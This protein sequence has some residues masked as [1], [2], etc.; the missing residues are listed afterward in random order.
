M[1]Y[2]PTTIVDNFYEN[3]D[4][5]REFALSLEYKSSTDGSWPGVRTNELCEIDSNFFDLFCKKL[6]SLYYDLN[7]HEISW[8]VSSC[9]QLI[10]TF[11]KEENNI[12]NEGWIH[13]DVDSIFAG[14]IYLNPNPKPNWG[15]SIYKL[16]SGEI[17][18][19][20]QT[21]RMLNYKNSPNFNLKAYEKQLRFNNDKFIETVKIENV[22]NRLITYE[23]KEYHGVPSY[24]TESE[25]RLTQVFF[26]KEI[27]S[28]NP[29]PIIRTK[30][31]S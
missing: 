18:D 12:K 8:H 29:S 24:Y 4:S 15:T 7:Y 23:A 19:C 2:F 22:Y 20:L 6:F 9:F 28:S 13:S 5:I 30:Y 14:V 10:E 21:Q 26:V 17:N 25:P 3:P 27:K 16:K 31:C 11:S 1:E